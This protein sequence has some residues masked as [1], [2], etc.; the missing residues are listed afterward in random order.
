MMKGW[1]VLGSILF[2]VLLSACA[3][4]Q[5]AG[6]PPA[7]PREAPG[8]P[9]PV[10]A[11]DLPCAKVS[12]TGTLTVSFPA[13]SIY[14]AGA[15]LPKAEGLACLEVL[16]DWLKGVPRSNWRLTLSGESGQ[17]FDPLALAE[18]RSELLQRYFLRKGI[19][20]EGWQWQSAADQ[21]AQLQ[22]TELRDLP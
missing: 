16:T 2:A 18:K 13:G 22:L 7:E 3:A 4:P 1:Q 9:S 17:G 11:T 14:S 5:Q 20:T 12:S 15:V 6:T 8:K 10:V 21:D 19:A